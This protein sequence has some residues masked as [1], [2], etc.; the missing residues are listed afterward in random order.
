[1]LDD[2]SQEQ[3][4]ER[5]MPPIYDL[6]MIST[7]RYLT[8]YKLGSRIASDTKWYRSPPLLCRYRTYHCLKERVYYK[9]IYYG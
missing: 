2:I 5:R 6:G 8:V 7:Y 1:M 4:I 9:I 3:R